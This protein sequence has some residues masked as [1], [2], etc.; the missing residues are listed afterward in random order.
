MGFHWP[1]FFVSRDREAVAA[2]R[3]QVIEL[4]THVRFLEADRL[5]PQPRDEAGRYVSTKPDT[6]AKL[7]RL[8]SLLTDKQRAEARERGG[9]R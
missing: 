5:K 3:D 1:R 9:R 2:L 6:T 7:K 8:C 4:G